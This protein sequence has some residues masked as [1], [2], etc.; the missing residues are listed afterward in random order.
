MHDTRDR[1]KIS[2]KER[3][4]ERKKGDEKHNLL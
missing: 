4:R 2:A 1:I 3:K